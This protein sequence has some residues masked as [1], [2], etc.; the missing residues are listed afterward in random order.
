MRALV[1]SGEGELGIALADDIAEPIAAAD[2]AVIRV[3]A[4]GLNRGDLTVAALQPAGSRLGW[5][6]AG[7][8]ER[9]GAEGPAAGTRVVGLAVDR[10]GFAERVAVPT[11]YLA[12]IPGGVP[13]ATAAALPVAGLTA[14]YTLRN[15]GLLLGRT[16]LVTGAGGGVGRVA[17]QLA[18][19][20]GARVLARVGS[21]QRA[22]GL[23]GLGAAAVGTYDEPVTEPVDVLLD[24]VGGPVLRQAF[25]AVGADGQVVSFGNTSRA[26]LELPLDWGR[27][28]PGVTLRYVHLFRET[29]R[30]PVGRDLAGLL[31]LVA[32]GRLDP[33]VAVTAAWTDPGPVLAALHG[34]RVNGK[35]VL[36]L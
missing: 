20:A 21:P 9:P 32:R 16:V 5:D 24:S 6:V 10:D 3:S 14:L 11:R 28:R 1:S 17:V 27:S 13:D 8:V 25:Q 2:R 22:E 33:Q 30:R 31:D 12:V 7:T 34:R 15:A 23:T 26:P 19:A 18:A 36:T 4:V 35:A 29:P